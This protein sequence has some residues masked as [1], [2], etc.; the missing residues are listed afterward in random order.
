MFWRFKL[1]HYCSHW[2]LELFNMCVSK[3]VIPFNYQK[4]PVQEC[5]LDLGNP[6]HVIQ[7]ISRN[8]T[9]KNFMMFAA[10]WNIL[11][12]QIL[13][14]SVWKARSI[15][16]KKGCASNPTTCCSCFVGCDWTFRLHHPWKAE[17]V[18]SPPCVIGQ[19]PKHRPGRRKTDRNRMTVVIFE[20]ELLTWYRTVNFLDIQ[21]FMWNDSEW[22][23]YF[24]QII[25]FD[26]VACN[27]STPIGGSDHIWHAVVRW[28]HDCTYTVVSAIYN[29]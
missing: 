11:T 10:S 17:V 22:V 6:I 21:T 2:R 16:S 9:S 13:S 18:Q 27:P 1:V 8:H 28:W 7:P 20:C 23:S 29:L 19:V 3:L 25:G 14:P 4:I 26:K 12:L 15:W 24:S 5:Q